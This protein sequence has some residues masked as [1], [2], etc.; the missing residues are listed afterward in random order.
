LFQ[1]NFFRGKWKTGILLG[2]FVILLLELKLDFLISSLGLGI[3]TVGVALFSF[4]RHSRL[5][6]PIIMLLLLLG[7]FII[8]NQW[9]TLSFGIAF[10]SLNGYFLVKA[11]LLKEEKRINEE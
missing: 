8:S 9:Y 4:F 11:Y 6:S 1:S 2:I 7:Y 5:L 10:G 3:G